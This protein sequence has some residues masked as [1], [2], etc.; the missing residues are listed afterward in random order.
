MTRPSEVTLILKRMNHGEEGAADEL[1][2][3][4]YGELRRMAKGMM[5]QERKG[6]TLQATA[7]VH[8]AWLRL[9]GVQGEEWEGQGHFLRVAARAMRNLLVDHA[10]A[11]AA[12]KRGGDRERL[13]LDEMIA[14]YEDR[15]IDLLALNEAMEELQQMDPMLARLVEVRFFAGLANR[16]AAQ[17][18]GDSV[19]GT[20]RAWL[21]ARAFLRT[22]LDEG[23]GE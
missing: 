23:F 5:R 6:H 15:G 13:A 8:E 2:S 20:K 17:V 21:S 3:L 7:L 18:L 22:R 10:R 9:G 11:R 12:K 19:E 1:F 14:V 16:E 4:V